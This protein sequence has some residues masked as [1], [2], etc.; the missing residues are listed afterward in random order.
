MA[1][2]V[3]GVGHENY[4]YQGFAV[5]IKKRVLR[6]SYVRSG[7]IRLLT[8]LIDAVTGNSGMPDPRREQGFL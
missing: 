4:G 5:A 3:S 2:Y 1:G 6:H 7:P 8:A